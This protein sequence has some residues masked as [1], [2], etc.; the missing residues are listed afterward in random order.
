MTDTTALVGASNAF[1]LELYRRVRDRPGNLA[2]SPASISLALMMTWG[3]ARGRTADEMK[4]VLRLE[5]GAAEVMA[6][7][8]ELATGLQDPDRSLVLRIASKLFGE[9]SYHFEPAY[10]EAT[11]V[12]YGAP[13]EPV[14]FKIS[15][16]QARARINAWV[17]DR[18]EKRIA[19]LI[20]PRG[21]DDQTR[22]VLVNAIYFLADWAEPFDSHS[23]RDAPFFV[24]QGSSKPVPTMHRVGSY[25]LADDGE[26]KALEIPYQGHEMS[27][28]VLLPRDVGGAGALE[29]SLDES[30]LAA[31]LGSLRDERRVL[32]SLP[33]FDASQAEPLSL[34]ADLA[35][36]GMSDA[37]SPDA[38]DF[39]GIA[40][41]PSPAERLFIARV[42]H[43]AFVR[44]DEKGTEAAAATAITMAR[45]G[46]APQRSVEFKADHPFLFLIR[47]NATGLVLFIGRV[48]DPSAR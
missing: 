21:V 4:K 3:G 18:T 35:E 29:A 44:V 13:L 39:T 8:A 33:R 23:T 16:E 26:V 37:F 31:I 42:F 28:L 32:V 20:P 25:R 46:G 17:E 2:V 43:K 9:R 19:N 22:L 36:M 15:A 45:A 27:M 24:V 38:A 48:A 41:P 47:D 1:G 14:D 5:G 12:A 6:A 34:G 30:R 40:D 7:A 10:L 11:R